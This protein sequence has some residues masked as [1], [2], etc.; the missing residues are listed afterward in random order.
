[1]EHLDARDRRVV[2]DPSDVVIRRIANGSPVLVVPRMV[3]PPAQDARDVFG[4][5]H[6][7]SIELEQAIE[8]V[9][10]P[11]DLRLPH[12]SA[13]LT[14]ARMTAFRPGAS[15]PPVRTP[16]FLM[17]LGMVNE[18]RQ[19]GPC[20]RVGSEPNGKCRIF[21][22]FASIA[23][24]RGALP[25]AVKGASARCEAARARATLRGPIA[26]NE[27]A[28]RTDLPRGRLAQLG[29]RCVRNAEVRGSIPLPSTI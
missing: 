9:F 16:I 27:L 10:E 17:G 24:D 2:L 4:V 25:A 15:P 23:L 18:D 3:P 26:E 20:R 11:D 1:M 8:A 29:E 7:A 22:S 21:K 28:I 14:T 19:M 12:C 5:Q 13:A 6:A